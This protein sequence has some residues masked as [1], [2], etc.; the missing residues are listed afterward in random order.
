MDW[1]LAIRRNREAL[2]G[3]VA[4][5]IV[6]AGQRDMLSHL[7]KLEWGGANDSFEPKADVR[8]ARSTRR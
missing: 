5:L 8:I 3:I 2:L 7:G 1:E 4:G 6:L